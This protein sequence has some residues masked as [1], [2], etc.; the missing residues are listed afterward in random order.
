[1]GDMV[2]TTAMAINASSEAFRQGFVRGY[3]QGFRQYNG[4]GNQRNRTNN[5]GDWGS[6]LGGI[7]GRP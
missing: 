3:D 2:E 1:M 7:L 5:S 4:N 6:V